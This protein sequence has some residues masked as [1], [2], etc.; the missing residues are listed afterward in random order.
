MLEGQYNLWYI[1]QGYV[2]WKHVFFSKQPEDLATLHE[3]KHK[4][5]I[6]FVLKGF[7]KVNDEWM[8]YASQ[9]VLFILDVID[10]L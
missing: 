9:E 4:V 6:L 3:I 7:K 5:E 1:K 8:W 2:I 10:L